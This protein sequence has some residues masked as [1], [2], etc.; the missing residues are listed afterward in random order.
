MTQVSLVRRILPVCALFSVLACNRGLSRDEALRSINTHSTIRTTDDVTIDA[1]SQSGPNEAI[2]RATLL[3]RTTNLKLRRFDS[4]WT[5]EFVETKV[6]GW[7][8]PETAMAELREPDRQKRAT[9]WADAHRAEYTRTAWALHILAIYVP[10]GR[11]GAVPFTI[12]QSLDKRH[13][14]AVFFDHRPDDCGC[15]A[16]CCP[17]AE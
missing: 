11:P 4:G 12:P 3:G 5:W 6:G 7:I 14:M 10:G 2:V 13:R 15:C 16:T 9:A 17:D 1:L 8:P